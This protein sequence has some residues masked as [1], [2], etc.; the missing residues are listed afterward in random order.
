MIPL[1]CQTNR[2]VDPRFP[3]G[4]AVD[5]DENSH[6][7]HE[8]IFQVVLDTAVDAVLVIDRLGNI[9]LANPAVEAMFG[10]SL[11]ELIGHPVTMLMPQS[12]AHAHPGFVERYLETGERCIIG[13]GREVE[14]R[15]HD[16]TLFPAHLS[17][18]EVTLTVRYLFAGLIRDNTEQK[19]LE[20][21]ARVRLTE[22]A[23]GARL[24]ELGEMVSSIA[25]EVNQ[26]LTA[27]VTFAAASARL[28]AQ[29]N[30][31]SQ[32]LQD[33]LAQIVTQG[34]R[35]AHIIQGIRDLT[36]KPS[37][38]HELV[39]VVALFDDVL[40]L[41]TH[42]VERFG[43]RVHRTFVAQSAHVMANRVQLEQV[44]INLLRNAFEALGMDD[45]P[46]RDV[47]VTSDND[48]ENVVIRVRDNG[49][50]F[51]L[52]DIDQVFENFYT[53]KPDGVGVG[54]GICRSIIESHGG[55]LWADAPDEGG[56][57]FSFILPELRS[58][59]QT[60]S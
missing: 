55:K 3:H 51:T 26:P 24:L 45:L 10:Y 43:V 28:L 56:A 4:D 18:S 44:V 14:G 7:E 13:S 21:R 27:I 11:G 37:R 29:G 57:Q 53:T 12:V 15:R 20:E 6:F 49:A 16:G 41:L 32:V 48:G 35:A 47:W 50:G 33:A 46:E 9:E 8:R 60:T 39:D 23:H 17:V 30:S 52:D 2:A 31:D 40:L 38:A 25:H 36:R 58:D 5:R 1:F 54:L 22:L 19:R 42:D 34:E 59:A